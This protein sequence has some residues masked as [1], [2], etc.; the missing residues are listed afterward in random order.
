[1]LRL[2]SALLGLIAFIAIAAVGVLLLVVEPRPLVTANAT[3][4]PAELRSFAALVKASDLEHPGIKRL[5]LT[6]TKLNAMADLGA[7]RLGGHARVRLGRGGAALVGSF[8]LG[9][10]LGYANLHVELRETAGV[11][12]VA[13]ARLGSLPL[14]AP[15]V[16]EL[17][18]LALDK[19]APAAELLR[20]SFEPDQVRALYRLRGD[21]KSAALA[22]LDDPERRRLGVR[23]AQ[24]AAIV[25]GQP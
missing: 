24:L 22:L 19:V 5:T 23:E 9:G 15:L 16:N 12:A 1:M 13:A 25:A 3:L 11:P 8:P 17:L 18:R 14:P 10:S 20:V 7:G 6:P 21:A 2:L 4:A